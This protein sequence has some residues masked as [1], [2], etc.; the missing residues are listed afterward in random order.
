MKR[1]SLLHLLMLA[2][3]AGGLVQRG[4]A[5]EQLPVAIIVYGN[6]VVVHEP[7]MAQVLLASLQDHVQGFNSS[8]SNCNSSSSRM[9]V[10]S[11]QPEDLANLPTRYRTAAYVIPLQGPSKT[12]Y[13]VSEAVSTVQINSSS[14]SVLTRT[15]LSLRSFVSGGGSLVLLGNTG[16]ERSLG[17]IASVLGRPHGCEPATARFRV[18]GRDSSAGIPALLGNLPDLVLP[19]GGAGGEGGGLGLL[20]CQSVINTTSSS[21]TAVTHPAAVALFSVADG[22]PASVGP[23]FVWA[24]GRG[25]VVWLGATF[26]QRTMTDDWV[27]VLATAVKAPTSADASR[28]PPAGE[29]GSQHP[30][31]R[32]RTGAT[33]TAL[34]THTIPCTSE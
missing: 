19:L 1:V 18:G 6:P 27:R 17:L 21:G 28:T 34:S 9:E 20:T 5:C 30:T 33:H 4:T 26:D 12:S 8:N 25:R 2:S 10:V 15:L 14:I 32:M 24:A 29:V 16:Q 22:V 11:R 3:A 7:E 13:A 23:A 31:Y